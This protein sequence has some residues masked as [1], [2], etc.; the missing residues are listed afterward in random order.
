MSDISKLFNETPREWLSIDPAKIPSETGIYA[1]FLKEGACLPPDLAECAKERV[2][3]DG[4]VYIGIAESG[5][6]TRL[7]QHLGITSRGYSTFRKALGAL[8][9]E[10]LGLVPTCKT[11]KY[12]YFFAGEGDSCLDEWMK[13][14]LLLKYIKRANPEEIEEDAIRQN[15]PPLNTKMN[16]QFVCRK[17]DHARRFCYREAEKNCKAEKNAC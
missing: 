2:R 17:L 3:G 11:S 4:L 1:I 12:N 8:L 7:K 6:K 5:L 13:K 16:E 15:R 14:F 9:R 10:K